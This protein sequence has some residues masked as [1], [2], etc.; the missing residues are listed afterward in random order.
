[1]PLTT[2]TRASAKAL[3]RAAELA[4]Y[5][6]TGYD[7]PQH[8]EFDALAPTS[9]L[10]VAQDPSGSPPDY[11]EP[12]HDEIDFSALPDDALAPTSDLYVAQDPRGVPR[13]VWTLTGYNE[14]NGVPQ[15]ELEWI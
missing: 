6:P 1:M 7:E 3:Q 12:Q 4:T 2:V 11:D 13:Q 10:Y 5:A 14:L 9:S 15:F 8:E